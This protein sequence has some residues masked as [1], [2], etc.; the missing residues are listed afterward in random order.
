MFKYT[1]LFVLMLLFTV[2]CGEPEDMNQVDEFNIIG[3]WDFDTVS[4]SGQIFGVPQSDKDDNPNGFIEFFSNGLGYSDFSIELLSQ[5]IAKQETIQWKRIDEFTIDI[6]E[7]DGAHEIWKL[8]NANDNMI[9][10]DWF[11][12]FGTGN[13]A[14]IKMMLVR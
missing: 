11:L 13:Q 12:D 9:E 10:A 1:F 7:E 14:T 2:G 8:I 4:G 6:E 3:K 5:T